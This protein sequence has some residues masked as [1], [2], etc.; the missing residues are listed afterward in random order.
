MNKVLSISTLTLFVLGLAA[1]NANNDITGVNAGKTA[2]ASVLST[3]PPAASE[4][5]PKV[6]VVV[7]NQPA[8]MRPKR[9]G[10]PTPTPIPIC[11]LGP[12]PRA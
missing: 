4:A 7:S 10:T 11:V 9:G 8:P 6:G 2:S 12:A 3:P 1:C 5:R